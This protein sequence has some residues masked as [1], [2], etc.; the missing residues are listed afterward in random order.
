MLDFRHAVA[1]RRAAYRLGRKSLEWADE[2]VLYWSLFIL[3]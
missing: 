3:P 2:T 1:Y